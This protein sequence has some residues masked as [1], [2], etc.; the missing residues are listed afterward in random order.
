MLLNGRKPFSGLDSRLKIRCA[1]DAGDPCARAGATA[2]RRY[3]ATMPRKPC[4]LATQIALLKDGQAGS[5]RNVRG[6]VPAPGQSFSRPGC[7]SELNV[8]SARASRG[9]RGGYAARGASPARDHRM[10][11]PVSV[12]VR[13]S[14]FDL[15]E[16]HRRRSKPGFGRRRFSALSSI[17]KWRLRVCRGA[18]PRASPVAA[19]CRPARRDIFC[20]ACGLR[21]SSV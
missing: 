18:D 1:R 12:A 13:L 10:E 9:K 15:H 2:I 19:S 5:V 11:R 17:W 7:F 4:A 8:L 14:G 3:R 21:R 16:K 20:F 6:I